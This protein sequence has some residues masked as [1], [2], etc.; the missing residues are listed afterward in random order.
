VVIVK[1]CQADLCEMAKYVIFELK[2][3]K[4]EVFSPCFR[5]IRAI[6]L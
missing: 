5:Q 6:G 2:I 3:R 4:I 1:R